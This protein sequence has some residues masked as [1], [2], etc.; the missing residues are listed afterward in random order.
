MLIAFFPL[1][2]TS[3]C[4]KEMCAFA[5]D[6]D[7]FAGKGVV[8]LPISVDSYATLKEYKQKL[9]MKVDLLSDFRR[10]VSS[11]YG[12]LLMDR[13]YSA[14]SYFLIDANGIL[15]W[16]H[17]E[18]NQSNRRENSEILEHIAALG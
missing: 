3:T 14:R 13:Y 12:V 9:G 5:D 7:Q 17:V 10:D 15:R 11:L 2:F 8:I 6:F 1:A 18:D 16:V 4:T